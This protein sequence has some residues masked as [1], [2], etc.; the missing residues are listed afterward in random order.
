MGYEVQARP[1]KV[2]MIIVAFLVALA[3]FLAYRNSNNAVS[4]ASSSGSADVASSASTS[5]RSSGRLRSVANEASDAASV[6]RRAATKEEAYAL[7]VPLAEN[8]SL[9]HLLAL[10]SIRSTCSEFDPAAQFRVSDVVSQ[11]IKATGEWTRA[12]E[13]LRDYCGGPSPYEPKV[14]QI[15]SNIQ[16]TI[17]KLAGEGDGLAEVMW[18]FQESGGKLPP[19]SAQKAAELVRAGADQE[20]LL[21][22]S[23]A[24]LTSLDTDVQA[25]D[26]RFSS[27]TAN[28]ARLVELKSAA[29]FMV[30]CA[31]GMDCRGNGPTQLQYCIVYGHCET[32]LP[33]QRYVEKYLLTPDELRSARAYAQ[34][35]APAG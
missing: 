7:L 22:A 26:A 32:G 9:E 10:E 23:N 31:N 3:L 18:T 6:A 28:P 30:S 12:Y 14:S 1:I 15:T 4:Q 35:L 11:D 27:A 29:S 24:F 8:G 13:Q 5:S 20:V 19:E 34:L 25:L 2:V 21:R 17:S 33:L 16:A